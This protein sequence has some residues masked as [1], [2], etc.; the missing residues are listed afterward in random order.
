V[1]LLLGIA[2]AALLETMDDRIVDETG[3]L[4]LE[5]VAYLGTVEISTRS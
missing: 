5:G 4:S 3:I 2:L 1:A